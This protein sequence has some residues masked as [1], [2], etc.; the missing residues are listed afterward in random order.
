MKKLL[1][2]LTTIMLML[3]LACM[4]TSCKHK[5]KWGKW[6]EVQAVTCTQSGI[7]ERIC[8]D[9]GE[10]ETDT[11]GVETGHFFGEWITTKATCTEDGFK[12]RACT[13][14]GDK[15]TETIR[16]RG[17]HDFI[18]A[19]TTEAT[20][21]TDG[22]TTGTCECGAK[23]T[24]VIAARHNYEKGVCTKCSRGLINIILPETPITV[25]DYVGSNISVTTKMT[26]L[27]IGEIE[28]NYNDTYSI[29][30]YWA[31]EKI[32]DRSGNSHSSRCNFGYKLYDSQGFVVYSSSN[33]STAVNVGEKFKDQE[34]GPSFLK[35]DP[36]E[37]YTLEILNVS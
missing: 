6:K 37:T 16:A 5:H 15:E 29:T 7:E 36:N 23:K 26:S 22:V 11:Y 18:W 27:K 13:N 12:E 14:C 32:Y 19:T 8:E 28:K 3:A 35:L 4:L 25:H 34:F 9:C 1:L 20:C 10:R 33:S 31:G 30:F 24:E 2:V 17:Y 21:T